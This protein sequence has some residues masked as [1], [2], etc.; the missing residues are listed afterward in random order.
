MLYLTNLKINL[1]GKSFSLRKTVLSHGWVN[2]PPY[3]YDYKNN[4]LCRTEIIND[5]LVELFISQKDNFVTVKI[6]SKEKLDKSAKNEIKKKVH[7]IFQLDINLDEFCALAK[8]TNKK[9]FRYI[10]A[11]G[12]RFLIGNSLFEDVV[13]TLFTTNT[14]WNQTVNMTEKFI[15]Q[16]NKIKYKTPMICGFPTYC[17]FK[18]IKPNKVIKGLRLGYRNE[19]LENIISKFLEKDGFINNDKRTIINELKRV[20]GIGKYSIAHI[21]CLMGMFDEIPIDSEV[22]KYAKL[23]GIGHN[24][25]QITEY[26]Q[27][28]ERYAFLAYKIERIVNKINWIG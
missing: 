4:V 2:L 7:N 11:G 8:Q 9:I 21:K 25:K 1:K 26:Y 5:N 18:K 16:F 6:K 24:E 3:R 15:S 28:Y 13:K 22:I 20:K 19:Y 27:K 10:K 14:T 17:E 12:G 23:K